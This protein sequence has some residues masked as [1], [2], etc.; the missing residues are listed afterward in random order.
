MLAVQLRLVIVYIRLS[1]FKERLRY[2]SQR[3]LYFSVAWESVFIVILK[4]KHDFVFIRTYFY[5]KL[6]SFIV[7]QINHL[8]KIAQPFKTGPFE[9][10]LDCIRF[11]SRL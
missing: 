8:K 1:L 9:I 7:L 10:S 3:I 4:L 2:I 5:S 11:F 6:F